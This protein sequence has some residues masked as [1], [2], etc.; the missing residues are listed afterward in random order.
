MN[1][2]VS[3]SGGI[4]S[5]YNCYKQLKDGHN[6]VGIY[7]ELSNNV[8]KVEE[9]EKALKVIVPILEEMFPDTFRYDGVSSKFNMRG[10]DGLYLSQPLVWLI[11]LLYYSSGY[12][13]IDIGYVS[14]DDA[15]SWIDEVKEAWRAMSAFSKEFVPLNFPLMKEKKEYFIPLMP[16]SLFDA[17][18]FCENPREGKRCGKCGACVRRRNMEYSEVID[19]KYWLFRGCE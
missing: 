8:N 17:C 10:G 11:G 1:I 18:V 16:R 5:V 2:L 3:L 15:I 4:D 14:G 7:I 12:D 6:V 19:K 9:E 13:R